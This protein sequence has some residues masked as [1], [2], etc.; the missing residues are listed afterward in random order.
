MSEL[1]DI[2]YTHNPDTLV[3]DIKVV[4]RLCGTYYSESD[5]F[6][7]ALDNLLRFTKWV[8]LGTDGKLEQDD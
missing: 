1:K 4:E 3:N 8:V 2:K 5:E 7:N 6:Y